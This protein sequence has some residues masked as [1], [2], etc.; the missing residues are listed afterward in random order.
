MGKKGGK[1]ITT[2]PT[3]K[4]KKKKKKN[5]Y[6]YIYTHTYTCKVSLKQYHVTVFFEGTDSKSFQLSKPRHYQNC[7]NLLLRK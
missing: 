5:I 2:P 1:K 7:K 4:K 6:I 3:Q